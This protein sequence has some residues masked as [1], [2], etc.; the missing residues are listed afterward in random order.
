MQNRTSYAARLRLLSRMA[1]GRRSPP[2]ASLNTARSLSRA[3]AAQ[4]A[5]RERTRTDRQQ[6]SVHLRKIAGGLAARR[7]LSNS[8][9]EK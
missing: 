8:Q 7:Q 5:Q 1:A 9:K 2:S 3:L 6:S 4:N